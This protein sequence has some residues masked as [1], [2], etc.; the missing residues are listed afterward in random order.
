M[1]DHVARFEQALKMS[2]CVPAAVG[3]F[4]RRCE[5]LRALIRTVDEQMERIR[6]KVKSDEAMINE[7]ARL[8]DQKEQ[9]NS[10]LTRT[11]Q[12]IADIL[13]MT[14]RII[15]ASCLVDATG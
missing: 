2:A 8:R 11:D 9:L 14:H 12:K 15:S 5:T 7:L 10:A 3:P 1:D 4:E 13:D 6:G